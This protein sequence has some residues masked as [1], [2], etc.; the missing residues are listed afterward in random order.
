MVQI[1]LLRV[2]QTLLDSVPYKNGQYI[3]T[4]TGNIYADFPG[5]QRLKMGITLGVDNNSAIEISEGENG[6]T[7]LSFNEKT[8]NLADIA[9]TA[10]INDLQQDDDFIILNCGTSTTN[11]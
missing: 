8:L 4:D 3:L 6:V 11:I 7:I 9:K 5:N 1:Q 2:K 10:N